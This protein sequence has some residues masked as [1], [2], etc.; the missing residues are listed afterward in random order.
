MSDCL[1]CL[2]C[3]S[4]DAVSLWANGAHGFNGL[5][6]LNY[7]NARRCV[8]CGFTWDGEPPRPKI[9]LATLKKSD[10]LFIRRPALIVT[11]CPGWNGTFNI[12]DDDGD[13]AA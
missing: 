5:M 3:G 12:P 10:E 13:D 11:T 9:N 4:P 6:S 1:P 2:E 7:P 8:D